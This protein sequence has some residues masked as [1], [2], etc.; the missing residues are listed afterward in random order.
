MPEQLDALLRERVRPLDLLDGLLP[1]GH[2]H[3]QVAGGG[4]AGQDHRGLGDLVQE[5]LNVADL[6]KIGIKGYFVLWKE[7]TRKTI[8]GDFSTTSCMF[9]KEKRQL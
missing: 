6:K 1:L 8:D 4:R 7:Q 5:V 3:A 2:G 9:Q